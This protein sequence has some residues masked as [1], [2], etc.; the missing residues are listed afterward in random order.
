MPKFYL[1]HGE[2][3]GIL[4]VRINTD[5]RLDSRNAGGQDFDGILAPETIP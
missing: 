3:S 2:K 5:E 4:G 1:L